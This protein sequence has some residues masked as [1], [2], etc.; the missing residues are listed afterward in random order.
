MRRKQ[1]KDTGKFRLSDM[2]TK[3]KQ[4][5]KY[6]KRLLSDLDI[7]GLEWSQERALKEVDRLEQKY[8]RVES[9]FEI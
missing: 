2:T 6:Y 8:N 3:D 4:D 9:D 7:N 5:Y 1:L